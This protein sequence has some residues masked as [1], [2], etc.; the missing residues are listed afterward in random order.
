MTAVGRRWTALLLIVA[1]AFAATLFAAGTALARDAHVR[2]FDGTKILVH[3]FPAAGLKAH[4]RAPTVLMGPGWGQLGSTDENSKTSTAGGVVGIGV[5]RA[6]G[7][8]VLTW[9]PRGFGG[10]GG[11]AEVDSPK[12]E[13]RDVSAMISWVARQPEALLD[14]S[15]DPRVGMVGGSYGGGIQLVSAAIDHRIDAIVPDIA[16]HSLKTS[17]DKNDTAKSGWGIPLYQA[18]VL[19]HARLDRHI[20]HSATQEMNSFTTDPADIRWFANRGPGALV[21]KITAPTLLIQGTVDT[22]FTLREAVENYDALRAHHV[23]VKMLWFCGGHGVCLT[24]PGNTG[25][26][27]RDTLAWL[28]RYLQRKPHVRTGPGFE[29]LDQNGRSYSAPGY[30]LRTAGSLNGHGSGTLPLIASG[31]SGPAPLPPSASGLLGSIGGNFAAAKATNAVDVPIRAPSHTAIVMGAPRLSFTYKGTAPDANA[32]VLAQVL[33][34]STGKVLDNQ[35]TPI[36][37]RLDGHKHSVSLPLEIITATA[38]HGSRFA[39]QLVAQSV[40][41]NTHPQGGSIT[42]S[43]VGVSVPLV[44]P[45]K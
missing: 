10:S 7:Y 23:P 12:F 31:G 11:T 9:D 27:Q 43:N 4:H 15:G 13:G 28:G 36:V 18:A 37:V 2:S 8:N 30:P 20:T 16:W 1:G 45:G 24:N 22:L 33:D 5:L 6:H 39:V 40:L 44:G 19:A 38:K 21:N 26:I 42:F 41:Y 29:W 17:L 25:R 32:R 3:F 14:K 34:E 35:I